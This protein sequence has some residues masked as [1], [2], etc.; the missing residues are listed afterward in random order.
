MLR[1]LAVL[2]LIGAIVAP[3]LARETKDKASFRVYFVGNSIIDT[4]NLS[5]AG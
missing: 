5:C 2:V 3:I 4:I 1:Q